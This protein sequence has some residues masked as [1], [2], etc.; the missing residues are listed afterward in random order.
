VTR[1]RGAA[2]VEF[3]L[4]TPVLVLIMLF[5]VGLGRFGVAQGDVNGA[6]RDA[7]RAASIARSATDAKTAGEAA[8]QATLAERQVPC[9]TVS[10]NVNP[11]PFTPGSD[12]VADVTCVV[13]LRDVSQFW[14]PGSVTIQSRFVST[15]DAFRGVHNP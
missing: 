11:G 10:V 13:A 4:I 2:T 14:T 6:A 5:I 1:E 8:A 9:Q 15:I 12:V 3:V 7:A